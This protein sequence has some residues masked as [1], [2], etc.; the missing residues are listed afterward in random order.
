[1]AGQV[2]VLD[3]ITGKGGITEHNQLAFALLTPVMHRA[4][5]LR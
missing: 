2:E 4:H 3:G 1:M 5:L